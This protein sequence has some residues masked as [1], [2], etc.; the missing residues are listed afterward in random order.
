M[1]ESVSELNGET[2]QLVQGEGKAG[3]GS[4]GWG[5]LGQVLPPHP[6]IP[7][8]PQCELSS[9]DTLGYCLGKESIVFS[10]SKIS[11]GGSWQ[12]TKTF[13]VPRE[14]QGTDLK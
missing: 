14:T 13:L 8:A 3:Q 10:S 6:N 9:R 11:V 7:E 4:G 2:L 12:R 1:T 5:R